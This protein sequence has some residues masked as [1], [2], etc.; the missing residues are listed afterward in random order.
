MLAQRGHLFAWAPV[1]LAIGIGVYFL[2]RFEPPVWALAGAAGVAALGAA[3][4]LRVGPE[5]APL[6]W[7]LALLLFGFA[8]AGTQARWLGAPVL[9]HRYYGPVEGRVVGR[10]RSSSDALR[11][12]L[13][14]V[15]LSGMAP[16]ETPARLR[17]SLHGEVQWHDPWPGDQV[18]V[19]AHLSP[20]T[21]PVEPGGF[22]FRRHAW[23]QQIG[24]VGYSRTP[25]L[26]LAPASEPQ[27]AP[28]VWARL[29]QGLARGRL[30][31]AAQIQQALPG[32]R[33]QFAAAIITGDRSAIRAG[34]LHNLR[35][36]NLAHLLA[37]SGLHMGLVSGF[38]FGFVRLLLALV[39]LLALR[40]PVKQIAAV[41][42]LLVAAAYLALSGGNVATQRAFIMVAVMF[43]A[44]LCNRRALTLRAV[45]L[46]AILVLLWQPQSLVSPGFQM[47]FAAT[48]ALVVVFDKLRRRGWT[49]GGIWRA[50]L[51]LLISSSVAGVATAPLA[52]AHFNQIAQFGLLANLLAVPV[53]GSLVIPSAVL[54]LL[55][56]PLGLA[57]PAFWVLGQALAWILGV[58][59]EVGQNAEAVRAVPSPAATVL[60]LLTLGILW[61][62][63]WQGRARG[64]GIAPAS[65]AL[66][67]WGY[68]ARP[69]LLIAPE[70][71]LVGL[72]V[73]AQRALSKEKGAG[74]VATLWLENDGSVQS[75]AE[76]AALWPSE[77]HLGEVPLRVISGK[78]AAAQANCH[79]GEWVIS[80]QPLPKGLPCRTF[81]PVTL[82]PVGAVAVFLEDEGLRVLS[83]R[84]VTGQ[85]LWTPDAPSQQE[86]IGPD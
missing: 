73:G 84:E 29:G 83:S 27:V 12:L 65:L 72:K 47:S 67:L 77:P 11:L 28:G 43:G 34:T 81:E 64:L 10:D 71:A 15:V 57:D 75:Q 86:S 55:L 6:V 85:R 3:T 8:W 32:E 62:M 42:A 20:P 53:M 5:V 44:I 70:G 49:M 48:T 36:S 37:I 76:A 18:I 31:L 16:G 51:A 46:A 13:D 78:R 35:R 1:C 66:A 24:A 33:G 82:A 25:L 69:D 38:V 2:L 40:L 50:P 56:L 21:G 80:N 17:L 45:A 58:A 9:S 68:G 26:L 79:A 74:F 61:M 4:S 23:F 14:Q 60:P 22:D 19:T 54:A 63:L 59:A 7:A 39:P 41:I 52:A 30:R